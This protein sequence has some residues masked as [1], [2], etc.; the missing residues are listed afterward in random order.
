MY[1]P[2]QAQDFISLSAFFKDK[3]FYCM[4]S[5][6]T[7]LNIFQFWPGITCTTPQNVLI[8]ERLNHFDLLCQ[9]D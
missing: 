7:T 9:I 5:M 3:M 4:S 6:H 1:Y 2:T 8:F